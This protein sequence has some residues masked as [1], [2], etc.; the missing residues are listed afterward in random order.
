[1]EGE[2]DKEGLC[3]GGEEEPSPPSLPVAPGDVEAVAMEGW[4]S[5][6]GL[7]QDEAAHIMEVL[8]RD[9]HLRQLED[10]K[11][12]ELKEHLQEKKSMMGLLA[13]QEAFNDKCCI[14]CYSPFLIL[15]N[16]RER[17]QSCCLYVCRDCSA[18]NRQAKARLCSVCL[19]QRLLKA[20]SFEWY[21][22]MVRKR[23]KQFGSAKVKLWLSQLLQ[24]P[25]KQEEEEV[26]VVEGE[27]VENVENGGYKR[28]K[29]DTQMSEE[30]VIA[31]RMAQDAVQ[32]AVDTAEAEADSLEAQ[33]ELQFLK[34]HRMEVTEELT[35]TIYQQ[36]MRRH[37][38]SQASATVEWSRER[39][40]SR[41]LSVPSTVSEQVFN[42]TR[43]DWYH[44]AA[45]RRARS[46]FIVSNWKV[47]EDGPEL[48]MESED[49]A[50]EHGFSAQ[51]RA[52]KPRR[53]SSRLTDG[54]ASGR[55]RTRSQEDA[56]GPRR[57]RLGSSDSESGRVQR[58]A[59]SRPLA[60]SAKNSERDEFPPE[61]DTRPR[62]RRSMQQQRPTRSLAASM[63]AM[64][65]HLGSNE[66]LYTSNQLPLLVKRLIAIEQSL[67]RLEGRVGSSVALDEDAFN[68]H[69]ENRGS[70]QPP[71]EDERPDPPMDNGWATARRQQPQQHQRKQCGQQQEDEDQVERE[72]EAG[73]PLYRRFEESTEPL[74][75]FSDDGDEMQ[76]EPRRRNDGDRWK[77]ATQVTPGNSRAS[78]HVWRQ[79][80]RET[81]SPYSTDT[82]LSE[83][84]NQMAS[85]KAHLEDAES[86]VS[87]IENRIAALNMQ[88]RRS[89][90]QSM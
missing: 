37:R 34:E 62:R 71:F 10:R 35:T 47:M 5:A 57:A 31:L 27:A 46:D 59:L 72:D 4:L 44:E 81:S 60:D 12:G 16:S 87:D 33:N 85:T 26:V 54:S 68:Q 1:M 9:A 39:I 29:P 41:R 78:R 76:G 65:P 43:T 56:D 45:L 3:A 20:R 42:A 23:F 48:I 63:E 86:Q 14:L 30:W 82:D 84:E 24:G 88:P 90:T 17:C 11:I 6:C 83:L 69:N 75:D 25:Q 89:G 22:D 8:Q 73:R 49:S 77:P 51:H 66:R 13:R 64:A 21:Y 61:E 38:S 36:L 19:K 50:G 74:S 7:S 52:A 28:I 32:D 18:Y 40:G 67:Y 58:S 55:A 53:S 2:G 79:R 15:I 80:N 70:A